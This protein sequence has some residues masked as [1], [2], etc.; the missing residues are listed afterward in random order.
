MMMMAMIADRA[1]VLPLYY[2][3][4]REGENRN[5]FLNHSDGGGWRDESTT[6]GRVATNDLLRKFIKMFFIISMGLCSAAVH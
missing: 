5:F 6:C 1:V 3:N 4:R 2:V